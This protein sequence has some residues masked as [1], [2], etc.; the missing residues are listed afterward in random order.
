MGDLRCANDR[1]T[2]RF[3]SVVP[4]AE[5]GA[6]RRYSDLNYIY[7]DGKISMGS[8]QLM[9]GSDHLNPINL[10]A[11]SVC[12]DSDRDAFVNWCGDIYL[13]DPHGV[14]KFMVGNAGASLV[15]FV[16]NNIEKPD[17][18]GNYMGGN[19]FCNNK[20]LFHYSY[21]RYIENQIRE[22]FS[23]D[24]T[25]IRIVVRERGDEKNAKA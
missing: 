21:Q 15:P 16:S 9:M 2:V 18:E 17:Y 1:V 20:E 6:P 11:G 5:Y 4:R 25:P 8:S 22:A 3:D 12:M 24:A 13:Q 7:V 10:Y 14:S 23:L 19:V